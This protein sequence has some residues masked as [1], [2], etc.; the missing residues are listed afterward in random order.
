M[1]IIMIEYLNEKD[2]LNISFYIFS[3]FLIKYFK[4]KAI[5]PLKLKLI[6]Y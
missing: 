5:Y 3:A 2:I 6:K 1:I 4:T